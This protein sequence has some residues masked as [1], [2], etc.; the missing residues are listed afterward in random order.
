V[1]LEQADQI[2]RAEVVEP[3][4]VALPE[5]ACGSEQPSVAR[6]RDRIDLAGIALADL[7]P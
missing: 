4:G 1:A 5:R 7:A 6:E 2:A 3:D